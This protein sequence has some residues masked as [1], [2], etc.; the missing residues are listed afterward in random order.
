M[1][2]KE[3]DIIWISEAMIVYGHSREW[4]TTRI[5]KG[6]LHKF[7]KLGDNKVYL[8]RREIEAEDTTHKRP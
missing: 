1:Q 4:F 8:S 2:P 7:P 6:A 3:S 5:K